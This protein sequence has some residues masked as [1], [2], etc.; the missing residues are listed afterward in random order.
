[1]SQFG[2]ERNVDNIRTSIDEEN[3]KGNKVFRFKQGK[4]LIRIMPPFNANGKWHKETQ[5]YFFDCPDLEKRVYISP[6]PGGRDPLYEY[7]AMM[8][9]KGGPDNI[10]TA[11]LLRAKKKIYVNAVVLQ[12]PDNAE[13]T[14]KIVTMQIPITV[15]KQLLEHDIDEA[16]GWGNITSP[17]NGVNVWITREGST[18]QD[19]RY[20]MMLLPHRTNILTIMKEM[21]HDLTEQTLPDLDQMFVPNSPEELKEVLEVLKSS[22]YL[23]QS[24][25]PSPQVSF[26]SQGPNTYHTSSTVVRTSVEPGQL[27]KQLGIDAPDEAG[28]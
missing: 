1:M 13:L 2:Y 5:E 23:D 9:K 20:T 4:T 10:A 18:V 16:Q 15:A 25:D 6:R 27:L 8:Y 21:G 17:T 26:R 19:T 24:G 28:A 7:G 11:K 14:D 3:N 12:S 22:G